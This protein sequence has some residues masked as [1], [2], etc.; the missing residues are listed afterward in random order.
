MLY[1]IETTQKALLVKNNDGQ[2]ECIIR[3]DKATYAKM[4]KYK[5]VYLGEDEYNLNIDDYST[6][7]SFLNL[8]GD[9]NETDDYITNGIIE[10]EL[11]YKTGDK[12]YS[13]TVDG[14]ELSSHSGIGDVVIKKDT[15]ID[16]LLDYS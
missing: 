12:Y 14:L 9:S 1:E 8:A 6:N 13:C 2:T 16:Y 3:T 15:P 5:K 11:N 4:C 10:Q 7:Y